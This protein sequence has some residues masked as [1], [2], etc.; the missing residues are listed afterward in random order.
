MCFDR[1]NKQASRAHSYL[2]F[3]IFALAVLTVVIKDISSIYTITQS[4]RG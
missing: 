4:I 3:P 1:E 2:A